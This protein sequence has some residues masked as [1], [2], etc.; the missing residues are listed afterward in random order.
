MA[1]HPLVAGT[2]DVS[3]AVPGF[4]TM[5]GT[6]TRTV[7][8]TQ[9]VISVSLS[10]SQVGSGLQEVGSV[11]LSASNH[12]GAAVTVTSS[13]PAVLLVSGAAGTVGQAQVT[14]TFAPNQTGANFYMQALEGATGAVTI[15]ASEPRF[16]SGS[17]TVTA[18]Q[19]GV[20]I[21]GLPTST[22]TLSPDV[23]FY[24]QVGV[25][26]GQ[27]TALQ[28]LQAVRAGGTTQV[29]TFT[30]G[31]P[32][33]G[34]IVDSTSGPGGGAT[35]TARIPPGQYFT[36]F[37]SPA[38]GGVAFHPVLSGTTV[39]SVAIPGFAT[40]TTTGFR[41]VALS[42][43]GVT[44]FVNVSQVGSG[45]QEGA[46]GQL[47][48]PNHGGVTVT[49]T[50]SNPSVL[51]LSPDPSTPG[52]A[53]IQRSVAD[54]V[55]GFSFVTQGV[56]GATGTVTITATASGFTNGTVTQ[57]VVQPGIEIQGLAST[58]SAGAPDAPFFAQVGILNGQGTALVR[59]Q[60]LRAGAPGP[61]TVTF[62]SSAPG[63]GAI[64]D[65]A[66][67]PAVSK[68]AQ[69]APGLYYTPFSVAQGGVAFHPVAAGSTD[70]TV[71]AAPGYVPAITTGNRT[72]TVQ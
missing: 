20:E 16:T 15:T 11:F 62:T 12:G 28:R 63:V 58:M 43:P 66:G 34:T 51:L 41:T 13:D 30:S 61:V 42:Q 5:T 54:G 18:V 59:V 14:L 67:P 9:P 37:G 3:V 19:P 72:V 6:G 2:T 69:I 71:S 32:A 21:Q 55:T 52:A 47:G 49:L 8:V 36:S 27:G 64:T 10:A 23:G 60:S 39:V 35:G 22:T 24:A 33:V 65:Q 46:S 1:F 17:A 26:N 45:L 70:V 44:L 40:M 29:A 25:P 38:Q 48:A 53:S 57:T 31:T 56:E 68:T 50:S 7:G 4:R